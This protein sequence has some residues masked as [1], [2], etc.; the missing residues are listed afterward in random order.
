[1]LQNQVERVSVYWIFRATPLLVSMV[2]FADA[3][4]P[5]VQLTPPPGVFIQFGDSAQKGTERLNFF[6][7]TQVSWFADF[8]IDKAGENSAFT[9]WYYWKTLKMDVCGF[10]RELE[11]KA[12]WFRFRSSLEE[13]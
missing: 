2:L 3:F 6:S 9:R 4:L 5:P 10:I 7:R 11:V 13:S 1:M 8:F 12:K